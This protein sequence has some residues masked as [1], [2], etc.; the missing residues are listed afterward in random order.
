MAASP[1]APSTEGNTVVSFTPDTLGDM[2]SSDA[3]LNSDPDAAVM[4]FVS[5]AGLEMQF[6]CTNW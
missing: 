5:G 6:R 3:Q 1:V 2:L 4:Q